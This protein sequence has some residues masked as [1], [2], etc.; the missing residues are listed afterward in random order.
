[1]TKNMREK[2]ESKQETSE[3][4]KENATNVFVMQKIQRKQEKNNKI[5]LIKLKNIEKTRENQ[6]TKYIFVVLY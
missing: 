5:P 6:S 3:C 2:R 1:M 4:F